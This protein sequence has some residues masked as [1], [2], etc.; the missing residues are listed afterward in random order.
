MTT[1]PNIAAAEARLREAQEEVTRLRAVHDAEVIAARDAAH[2]AL[3]PSFEEQGRTGKPT[4]ET[5]TDAVAEARRRGG[6]R[7]RSEQL[8]EGAGTTVAEMAV[9]SADGG[10]FTAAA[11]GRAEALRRIASRRGGR[12]A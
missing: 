2:A 1:T 9:R 5:V 6:G 12:A 4:Q 10:G 7:T 11:E 3:N 8:A